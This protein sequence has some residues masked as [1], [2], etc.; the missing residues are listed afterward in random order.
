M[1]KTPEL[2]MPRAKKVTTVC[3]GRRE[4]WTAVFFYR[5]IVILIS[6]I[7]SNSAI[8]GI[9]YYQNNDNAQVYNHC[10]HS[11][12][13]KKALTAETMRALICYSVKHISVDTVRLKNYFLSAIAACIA[14]ACCRTF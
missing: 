13:I 14:F 7:N 3:N 4:V 12:R 11:F 5:Q 6:I 8:R 2:A 10:S 1:L 9:I